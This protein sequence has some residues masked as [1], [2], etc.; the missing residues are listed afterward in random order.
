MLPTSI[1]ELITECLSS[2]LLIVFIYLS[3]HSF[4]FCCFFVSEHNLTAFQA[5][6]FKITSVSERFADLVSLY[7]SGAFFLLTLLSERR[8][9]RKNLEDLE[10][11]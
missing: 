3:L 9:E 5:L 2:S 6:H 8:K 11:D 7:K 10:D 1:H 4:V